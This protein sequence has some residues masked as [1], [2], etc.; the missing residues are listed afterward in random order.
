MQKILRLRED[1]FAFRKGDYNA[2]K[3]YKRDMLREV[4]SPKDGQVLVKLL[5][6]AESPP[7]YVPQYMVF[8]A[9]PG[10]YRAKRRFE[11]KYHRCIPEG[12]ILRVT[13]VNST[14]LVRVRSRGILMFI[15]QKF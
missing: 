7:T 8:E 13:Q 15:L 5:G 1:C 4:A 6:D 11:L 9:G 14:F 12:D 2:T 3:L 10:M